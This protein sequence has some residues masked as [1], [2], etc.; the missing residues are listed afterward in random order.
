[1]PSSPR[2]MHLGWM[3]TDYF[4][5]VQKGSAGAG[6]GIF[7]RWRSEPVAK[8]LKVLFACTCLEFLAMHVNHL[9]LV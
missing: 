3:D 1:M 9:D 7:W 6:T 8:R 5:G 4:A 2:R